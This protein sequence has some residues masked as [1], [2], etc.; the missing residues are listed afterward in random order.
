MTAALTPFLKP[1]DGLW[2][3]IEHL[4]E[5][6][7]AWFFPKFFKLLEKL[8]LGTFAYEPDERT[9]SRA[10]CFWLECQR[11]GIELSEFRLLNRGRELFVARWAGRVFV[12]DHLPRP[13]RTSP[14]LFWM[15]D[16]ARMRKE[17]A[18]AGI[19]VARGGRYFFWHKLAHDF[20]KLT[21]PVIVKPH[22][23]SRSR[24]TTTHI[25]TLEQLRTAFKKAKQLSPF[26]IMEEEHEGFVYRGTL[27]GKKL[28][29]I[30]RREPPCVM[31]DGVRT[32]TELIAEEN[33]HPL[34]NDEVFHP[35]MVGDEAQAELARQHFTLESVPE[36]G[37]VVMLAQKASRGLGGGITNV[38]DIAHP[39]NLALMNM[40][41]ERLDDPLVG[42]DFMMGDITRSWRD[43]ARSGV[44]ECNS[45]PFIDLHLL[46]LRG[47]P[48]NTAGLLC[49]LAF[50]GSKPKTF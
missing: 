3:R 36:Q 23:G 38:T 39:D 21:K 30:L 22:M 49:D 35:I 17:F 19:P 16:K 26:V 44:I 18:R 12:F 11:R 15:D 33:K 46:P 48:C 29:G 20:E 2:R 32:I 13:G 25:E 24:H 10:R 45:M 42:V 28:A 9:G 5:T 40:V 6:D 14:A 43:Q 50:P 4:F 8:R 1:V 34:R 37:R 27:I 47:E 41:A 31:S 7:N